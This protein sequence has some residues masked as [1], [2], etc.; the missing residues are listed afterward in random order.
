VGNLQ[1]RV[2]RRVESVI[3]LTVRNPTAIRRSFNLQSGTVLRHPVNPSQTIPMQ[4]QSLIGL[5]LIVG[6]S[7]SILSG[8]TADDLPKQEDLI[9]RGRYLAMGV[10][11]CVGCHS[12]KLSNGLL[13]PERILMGTEVRVAP[14]EPVA[15]WMDY[16]P[17]IAGLPTYS[18]EEVVEA[19]TTGTVGD[20]YLRPPMPVYEMNKEDAEAIV[21]YLASLQPPEAP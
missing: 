8:A 15:D 4:R 13:D 11:M 1:I 20:T 12:P 9:K 19:L 21:A 2:D 14:L 17:A 16:A 3:L 10:A 6:L 5:G 18:E 7:V